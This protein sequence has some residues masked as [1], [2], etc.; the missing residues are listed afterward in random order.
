LATGLVLWAIN[1]HLPN[2]TI[3]GVAQLQALKSLKNLVLEGTKVT[4]DGA[5]QLKKSLPKCQIR[6][7]QKK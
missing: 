7:A 1:H 5:E 3:R 4:D 6:I 2:R